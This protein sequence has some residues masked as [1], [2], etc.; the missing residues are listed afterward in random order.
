MEETLINFG[1]EIKVLS[2]TDDAWRVGGWAVVFGSEDASNLKDMFAADTDY[3]FEDGEARSLYYNHGLDGTIKKTRI[4]RATLELKDAGVWYEGEVKK[5]TDYLKAHAAKIVEGIKA[6]IYGTSTGA[7]AHLVE[8]EKTATGHA[9]KM[10]PISEIS[11]TPTPAEPLTSCVS[12]KSLV[13]LEVEGG[14]D[15]L[16]AD[17][18][19]RYDPD[20]PRGDD[21]RWSIV[22]GV[23][24]KHTGA[25]VKE[26]HIHEIADD[27]ELSGHARNALL[28]AHRDGKIKTDE[29]LYRTIA[30]A[31]D[32][33]DSSHSSQHHAIVKAAAELHGVGGTH[34]GK[35]WGDGGSVSVEKKKEKA[36]KS[37][38]E[39]DETDTPETKNL[40]EL[41][42]LLHDGIGFEAHSTK[43]LAAVEEF[44]E[45]GESL[46]TI[47]CE[48]DGRRWS[49]EKYQSLTATAN[50]LSQAADAIKAMAQAHA[51]RSVATPEVDS[52]VLDAILLDA[53]LTLQESAAPV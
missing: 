50:G 40:T 19:K 13:A 45:R 15:E 24:V 26:S 42:E 27:L 11:I 23:S 33:L 5:R 6:G 30:A 52:V 41:T 10:W 7:P 44:V 38:D 17:E 18:I 8:R 9:V 43:V 21:G 34:E 32:A 46:K 22:R 29:H 4:G 36:K 16:D 20:Q 2:E 25:K 39:T 14:T 3:D 47:R 37:F 48:R 28:K 53:R 31:Q 35:H 1:S 49:A 12:L 51:P